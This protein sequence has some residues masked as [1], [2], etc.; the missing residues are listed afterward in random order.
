[1][2]VARAP[3]IFARGLGMGIAEV[4][5]GVSGGTIAFVSGI[6]F[7]LVHALAQFGPRSLVL[8]REPRAFFEH[9]NLGFLLSLAAG[10]GLGVVLFARLMHYLLDTAPVLVWAF[11]FG[12]IA[13]S[14]VFI[15]RQRRPRHLLLFG[16]CGFLL[17]LGFMFLPQ[18]GSDGG[19]VAIFFGGVVA[20]CAWLLPAVSGSFVLLALGLYERV[21]AAIAGFELITLGVLACGCAS[22]LLVFAKVLS[23]LMRRFY[24]KLLSLLA[25][26]M[27]GSL[28]KLWP[29]RLPEVTGFEGLVSPSAY[30]AATG[31]QAFAG[32]ALVAV[33]LG[34]LALWLLTRF[35]R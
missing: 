6:Y 34:T 25:G 17:G 31:M 24:D 4:V 1:M 35:D 22:G 7:E 15:G 28:V 11:F 5:P 14:V 26:F 10:M 30:A 18:A 8:L 19:L 29:W 21:I 27:L 3:G 2:T 13:A 12:L 32:S 9:H 23:W 33:A 20:V 16:S